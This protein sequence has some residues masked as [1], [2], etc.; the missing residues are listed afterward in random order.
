[1]VFALHLLY[2]KIQPNWYI[3]YTINSTL[4][5]TEIIIQHHM[6]FNPRKANTN[7]YFPPMI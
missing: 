6:A 5:L 7:R 3:S 2:F 4:F 1:M